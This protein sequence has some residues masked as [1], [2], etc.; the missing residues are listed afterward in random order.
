M[1]LEKYS[2]S[3]IACFKQC[4][5]KFY[6]KY[7]QKNF[8]FN[9]NIATE[10]GTLVHETEEAIAKALQ[11][12]DSVNYIDLKNNFILKSRELA[13][14]YPVEYF[15]RDKSGQTYQEKTY[16]YLD[17][18]IYR[19][20]AFLVNHPELE[21]VGIEQ[22]FEFPYDDQHSF[23]GSIDRAFLNTKTKELLIQDIKTWPVPAHTSELKSPLQ[24]AIYSMAAEK[25][26]GIPLDKIKCEYDLPLCNMTQA[27][28]S[29]DL[30]SEG[31]KILNKLFAGIQG[32][33]FKPTVSALCHWCE[34]N[35]LVHPE[36]LEENP[37]AICPYFS[38]W[39]KSGDLVKDTLVSWQDLAA[40]ET[41]RQ[42]CISQLRQ[43]INN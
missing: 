4:H 5:F 43:Q 41:D 19:L 37:K 32:Q 11:T 13:L 30:V 35:P 17:S 10:F 29:T 38:K 12:G 39:Q 25:I 16:Y 20:E 1:P 26:W 15:A 18:A 3:K 40:V 22:H 21:I 24:F 6:L 27:T 14:K 2:Y 8:I 28:L 33:N 34:Y 42:V 36:L 31:C 23:N 9:A 7:F